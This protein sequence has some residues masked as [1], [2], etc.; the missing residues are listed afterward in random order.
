MTNKGTRTSKKK[1]GH[2]GGK[3]SRIRVIIGTI[4]YI[5]T[6]FLVVKKKKKTMKKLLYRN[7]IISSFIS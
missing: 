6:K 5:V 4:Y 2:P 3:G 7:F 1:A